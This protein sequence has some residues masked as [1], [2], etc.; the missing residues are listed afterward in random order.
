VEACPTDCIELTQEFELAS[1]NRAGMVWDR[2]QLEKG[3]EI[4]RYGRQLN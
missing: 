4:V 2:E 1:Y 3:R